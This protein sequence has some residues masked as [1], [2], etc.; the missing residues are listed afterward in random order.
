MKSLI[1]P[2]MEDGGEGVISFGLGGADDKAAE[3]RRMMEEKMKK[4]QEDLKKK[5]EERKNKQDE[6]GG[7]VTDKEKKPA[8]AKKVQKSVPDK[9][10][11]G[12]EETAQINKKPEVKSSKMKNDGRFH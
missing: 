3:K 11:D 4:R 5:A 12:T 8:V 1:R 9:A 10:E 2:A 6:A 7:A